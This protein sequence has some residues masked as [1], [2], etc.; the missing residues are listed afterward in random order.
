M[1]RNKNVAVLMPIDCTAVYRRPFFVCYFI[2]VLNLRFSPNRLLVF[3]RP[4][5]LCCIWIFIV[6]FKTNVAFY[7][8][9]KNQ[10][11]MILSSLDWNILFSLDLCYDLRKVTLALDFNEFS[12]QKCYGYAWILVLTFL[13]FSPSLYIFGT[14]QYKIQYIYSNVH[15]F[16]C[17]FINAFRL[18]KSAYADFMLWWGI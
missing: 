1:R 6:V 9:H 7:N 10:K 3:D 18:S 16:V 15:I 12:P 4:S 11:Y 8:G 17:I 5:D 14:C 2:Y 13:R